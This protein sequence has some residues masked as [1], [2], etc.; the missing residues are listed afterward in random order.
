MLVRPIDWGCRIHR[1]CL[2]R[3]VR[4][5]YPNEDTCLLCVVMLQDGMLMAEQPVTWQLKR[6]SDQK[7]S[8]LALTGI[9]RQSEKPDPI[10][11]LVMLNPDTILQ[12]VHV[13]KRYPTLLHLTTT[14]RWW[15]RVICAE[16]TILETIWTV[17]KQMINIRENYQDYRDFNPFNYA[18]TNN[19]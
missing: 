9:N 10:N 3:G 11:R 19:W 14:W 5:S 13:V 6:S 16:I 15:L 4:R 17:S 8:T 7:H 2:C 18:Q 1:L 12:I